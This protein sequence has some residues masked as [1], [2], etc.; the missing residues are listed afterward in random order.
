MASLG[1]G[2]SGRNE[3]ARGPEPAVELSARQLAGSHSGQRRRP[4]TP[5]KTSHPVTG[6]KVHGTGLRRT[7]FHTFQAAAI[8]YPNFYP[9]GQR[10]G[11][12]IAYLLVTA[13][14][15][16]G[17]RDCATSLPSWSCGFDS[18]RPLSTRVVSRSVDYRVLAGSRRQTGSH[19]SAEMS[20]LPD[21]R[22]YAQACISFYVQLARLC[23]S[24]NC[25]ATFSCRRM[26]PARLFTVRVTGHG[27]LLS[28][29]Y[30]R[31]L[32][33][34]GRRDTM[35][36][37]ADRWSTLGRAKFCGTPTAAVVSK[38]RCS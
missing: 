38:P 31:F 17:H 2:S 1:E 19:Y 12:E 28:K 15:P 20:T 37:T 13:A 10:S 30:F 25:C 16:S 18:R 32:G 33:G 3:L 23:R 34:H 11:I 4:D 8:F 22:D 27:W 5:G 7:S 35:I 29:R 9:N 26:Q 24:G 14:N 21:A 36:Y 6:I